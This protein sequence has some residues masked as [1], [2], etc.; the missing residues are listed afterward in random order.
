MVEVRW[1]SMMYPEIHKGPNVARPVANSFSDEI[2]K[3]TTFQEF[4]NML[5]QIYDE[6]LVFTR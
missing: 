3:T 1:E 5:R 4:R 6:F 2:A